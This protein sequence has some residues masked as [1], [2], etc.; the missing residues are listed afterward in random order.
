MTIQRIYSNNNNIKELKY[1]HLIIS[2]EIGENETE[3]AFKSFMIIIN[4]VYGTTQS[5]LKIIII[6]HDYWPT[7]TLSSDK[8]KLF[9]KI[10]SHKG[11]WIE[12]Y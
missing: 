5:I 10:I 6:N 8:Q 3:Y 2:E 1:G 9:K 12:F 4:Q 7:P 11:K